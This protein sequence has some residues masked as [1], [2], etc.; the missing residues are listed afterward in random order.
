MILR[1]QHRSNIRMRIPKLDH[2]ENNISQCTIQS[3]SWVKD[4]AIGDDSWGPCDKKHSYKQVTDFERLWSYDFLKLRTK[5]KDYWK[6][7]E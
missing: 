5:G 3:D 1:S 4:V 2:N 6:D 7:T